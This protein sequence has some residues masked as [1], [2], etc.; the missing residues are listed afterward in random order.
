MVVTEEL[1]QLFRDLQ[2]ILFTPYLIQ[3]FHN[4]KWMT[5]LI[6]SFKY[7]NN[8]TSKMKIDAE[9]ITVELGSGT[10]ILSSDWRT[11]GSIPD[12]WD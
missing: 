6:T 4:D 7:W 9:L 1:Q 11:G 8:T 5:V 12:Q 2:G 3:K 10:V